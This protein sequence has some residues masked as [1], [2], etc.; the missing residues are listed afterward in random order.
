MSEEKILGIDLGTTNTAVSVIEGGD[1]ST[2]LNAEGNR[3]TSSV[4]A[5]TKNGDVLVGDHAKN[6]AVTNP[7]NTVQSIKRH[8]GEDD[9]QVQLGDRIYTPEEISAIILR[10]VKADA[11]QYLGEEISKAVI[12]VPAYFK[13]KQRQATKDAG[14]IADLEVERILNE[15]TAAALA[16]DSHTI[17]DETI[18]VYDLGGGTFDV[19][20]MEVSNN[21]HDVIASRGNSN[22]GGDDWDKVIVDWILDKFEAKSGINLREEGDA[23]AIQRIRNAA[24]TAK[25]ELSSL[26]E[27]LISIPFIY[28][29]EHNQTYDIEEKLTRTEFES[30]SSHLVKKTRKPVKRALND[31][32]VAFQ[33]IDRVLL[34]GGATRMPMIKESLGRGERNVNPDEAV[35]RGAAIQGGILSGDIDDTVLL[36]VTPHS[37]GIEVDGGRF[38]PLITR[39]TKIPAAQSDTF[40]TARDNQT[41]VDIRVYQGE[42]T[43]AEENTL[44]DEFVL[45]GIPLAD[46]GVPKI[47][48]NFE[49][50]EDG[51]VNV[52]AE[53]MDSGQR[54][55]ITIE[56]GAGLSDSEIDDAK[57]KAKDAEAHRTDEMPTAAPEMDTNK[58]LGTLVVKAEIF[59]EM[60]QEKLPPAVLTELSNQIQIAEDVNNR[61]VDETEEEE[62]AKSL[63]VAIEKAK[64]VIES[65]VS[66]EIEH[67]PAE[68][69]SGEETATNGAEVFFENTEADF[70]EQEQSEGG[71]QAQEVE[72]SP[73]SF[74]NSVDEVL[75]IDDEDDDDEDDAGNLPIETE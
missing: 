66:E 68:S 16:Y 72:E 31:A 53:D 71:E 63:Q 3:T 28:S 48:V 27:T 35:A 45:T 7:E 11:E 18:M 44:L 54:E 69:S 40:T 9:Y 26:E 19:T 43:R 24:E 75:N 29:D 62:A 58:E 57:D 17:S 22:L 1:V 12:T 2:I 61:N 15:P 74:E 13:D 36:D 34:V 37:L 5:R 33:D 39:N 32:G 41:S 47:R 30:L 51:I 64:E 21:V 55:E 52:T 10:K 14:E 23:E 20:I 25:N 67:D 59:H 42:S 56:G 6:Q 73:D 49:V 46:A 70:S 65:G 60:H 50:D 4:V 8:M 38:R